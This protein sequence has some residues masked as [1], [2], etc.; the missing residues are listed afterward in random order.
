[1]DNIVQYKC[2]NKNR[3][4]NFHISGKYNHCETYLIGNYSI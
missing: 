2:L 4:H 1:M 3:K